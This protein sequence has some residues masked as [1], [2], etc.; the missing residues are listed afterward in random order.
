MKCASCAALLLAAAA[1]AQEA[2]EAGGYSAG[3]SKTAPE[4]R[5]T[6]H[7]SPEFTQDR[8]FA[9][10]RF[11]LLDPG[12]YEVE[13]WI[14]DKL[15]P[16]GTN[17]GLWQLEVEIGLAPHLQLDL[18]ENF[19]FGSAGFSRQGEQLELRVA[20]GS[21]YNSIPTNPVLYLEFAPKHAAQDRAEIRLLLGGDVGTHILWA[22]NLFAECNVDDFNASYAEG[23]DAEG[24]LTAA[25]SFAV[26]PEW[27][28]VGLEG[29]GGFDMH[30]SPTLYPSL[31]F[32]PNIL[33]TARP[34]H[35]KLTATALF[36]LIP[37]DPRVRLFLIAGVGF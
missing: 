21:Y 19:N 16:D 20:F 33:F 25:G 13:M 17:E 7:A 27:L 24:G 11:W 35:F 4:Y 9:G 26:V 36:G 1:S 15:Q 10:S 32:G 23:V 3:P 28:R 29:R 6:V 2:P 22:A 8:V 37:Q 34:A 14:D 12:R 31:M 30:G 5:T 18:Y